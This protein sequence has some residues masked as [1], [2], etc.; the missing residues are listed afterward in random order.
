MA[1]SPSSPGGT[2][3]MP[4]HATAVFPVVR[5]GGTAAAGMPGLDPKVL[6]RR[7]TRVGGAGFHVPER[8]RR[9]VR[10]PDH[11]AAIL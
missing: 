4:G 7:S 3:T 1:G 6:E 11:P 9:R 10:P 5:S 8:R 2:A